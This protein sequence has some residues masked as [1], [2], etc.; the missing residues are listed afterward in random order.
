MTLRLSFLVAEFRKIAGSSITVHIGDI[1][2]FRSLEQTDNRKNM[3]R[4]LFEL[5]HNLQNE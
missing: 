5:V 3:T 2:P 4:E 1:V